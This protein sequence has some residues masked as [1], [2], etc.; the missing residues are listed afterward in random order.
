MSSMTSGLRSTFTALAIAVSASQAVQAATIEWVDFSTFVPGAQSQSGFSSTNGLQ[1]DVSF[2]NLNGFN[3]GFPAGIATG[4]IDDPSWPYQNSDVPPSISVVGNQGIPISTTL[5]LEFTNP[6]GL[7][8]GGALAIMDLEFLA[9]SVMVTGIAGGDVVPVSWTFTSYSVAP[10]NVAPPVW[11]PLTSTL[12]GGGQAG[13]GA[14]TAEN[15]ALLVTDRPLDAVSLTILTSQDG[16]AFNVTQV[17]EPGASLLLAAGVAGL[18]LARRRTVRLSRPSS[19]RAR[20]AAL[21]V[22]H[23]L[24]SA[25]TADSRVRL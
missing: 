22:A 7:R 20:R 12:T 15:F 24:R 19:W 21:G 2:S 11:N 17:P 8:A 13:P 4:T 23:R 5:T 18:G 9:S 1:V 16:A 25:R 3:P 6:G 10:S 14:I